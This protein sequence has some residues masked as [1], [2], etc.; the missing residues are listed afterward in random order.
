MDQADS[1]SIARYSKNSRL[2]GVANT[3]ISEL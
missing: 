1:E 2:T 3:N